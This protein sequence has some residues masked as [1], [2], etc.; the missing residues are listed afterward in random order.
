MPELPSPY[1]QNDLIQIIGQASVE[2]AYLRSQIATLKE[3][4]AE[5]EKTPDNGVIRPAAEVLSPT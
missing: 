3:R 5:L 2:L 4:I 1:N